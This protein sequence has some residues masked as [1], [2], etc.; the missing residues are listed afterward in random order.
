MSDEQMQFCVTGLLRMKRA[1]G[2][3]VEAQKAVAKA[4]F[5]GEPRKDDVKCFEWYMRAAQQG[6]LEAQLNVATMYETGLG[7]EESAR[8]CVEW[9]ERVAEQG[10][11]SAQHRV[12]WY[13]CGA[14]TH[15]E[16][17]ALRDQ[18]QQ[19]QEHGHFRPPKEDIERAIKWWTAA[20]EQG[21]I[22]AMCAL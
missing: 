4:F 9:F 17:K 6:D 10:D 21:D 1:E 15:N 3:C 7:V 22:A 18:R 8:S 16:R 20:A 12:A 2:G 14:R 11:V 19:I 13:Y 5:N